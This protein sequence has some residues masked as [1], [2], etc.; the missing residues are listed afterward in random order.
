MFRG[1]EKRNAAAAGGKPLLKMRW[2]VLATADPSV[3]DGLEQHQ[4]Q[5]I[6]RGEAVLPRFHPLAVGNVVL[7][8]T[9]ENLLAIDFTTGKL[10]W[11]SPVGEP[12]AP[13]DRESARRGMMFFPPAMEAYSSG[14]RIWNDLTYGTLSSDGRYVY[15][16]EDDAPE[17][18]AAQGQAFGGFMGQRA[19]APNLAVRA[20][21]GPWG[22]GGVEMPLP[23]NHLAAHEI[24]TGKLKWEIGGPSG[25]RGLRQPDTFF[26]G[27]P[28]PLMG[29]LYVLAEQ[30]EEVRLLAL[31]PATGDLQWSQQLTGVEQSLLQYA[32]RRHMG[33][34]PSYADGILVC[35]TTTGALVGVDLANRSL[36]WA[37]C[38]TN[39]GNNRG[40][41]PPWAFMRGYDEGSDGASGWADSGAVIAEGRVLSTPRDSDSLLCLSLT[42]GHRVWKSPR[43]DDLYLA[44]TDREAGGA[45]GTDGSPRRAIE[46]RPAGLARPDRRFSR[47]RHAQRPGIPEREPLFRSLDLRRGGRH[48]SDDGKDRRSGQIA[49]GPRAGQPRGFQ[50]TD[51]FPGAGRGRGLLSGRGDARRDPAA[52]GQ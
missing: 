37:N 4:R 1:D 48:R 50:G 23:N 22:F 44:C 32:Y 38:Y 47:R 34:S 13:A 52:A 10:L 45:R 17:T 20:P 8:R 49:E 18:A 46:R 31:D 26:L 51:R 43:R 16:I 7:M 33:A 12:P 39:L 15:S 19:F 36:L 5:A 24:R 14:Q 35:P 40:M 41:R 30:N 2:R 28:L 29:S 6:E 3:Q 9:I 25:P 27:P 42:D 21:M 11:E